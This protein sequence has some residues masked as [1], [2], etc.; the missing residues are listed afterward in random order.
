MK[1][2][3]YR[4]ALFVLAFSFFVIFATNQCSGFMIDGLSKLVAFLVFTALIFFVVKYSQRL[5][6]LIAASIV[7]L[8]D[9]LFGLS[10]RPEVVTRTSHPVLVSDVLALP[11]RF[12]RPPP[13]I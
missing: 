3:Q 10:I 11:S 12:Q 13:A 9:I 2:L 6:E 1:I 8:A 4:R 5:C 7:R